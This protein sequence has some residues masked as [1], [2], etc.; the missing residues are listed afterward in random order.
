MFLGD[1]NIIFLNNLVY[2]KLVLIILYKTNL[3]RKVKDLSCPT[4]I[5]IFKIDWRFFTV[6]PYYLFY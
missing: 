4:S 1:W 2:Q 6:L 5:S 3:I